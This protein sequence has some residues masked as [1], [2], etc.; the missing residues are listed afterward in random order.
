[1]TKCIVEK[2]Y[3]S[4][5]YRIILF[6][7]NYYVLDV[8]KPYVVLIFPFLF[9]ILP[10]KVYRISAELAEELK[11]PSDL[12]QN[13]D[14]KKNLVKT[15]SFSM[16]GIIQILGVLTDNF[17]ISHLDT[18]ISRNISIIIAAFSLI[19]CVILRSYFGNLASS[20]LKSKLDLKE[21]EIIKIRP[22]SLKSEIGANLG[23]V[24]LIMFAFLGF[25]AYIYA[26]NIFML[27][28]FIG[29]SYMTLMWS[30]T[31][32]REDACYIKNINNEN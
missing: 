1:M 12:K 18:N 21:I 29:L 27:V 6:K 7:N 24:F 14:K 10:H 32:V 19:I 23:Y 3:K 31:N 11:V 25:S 9:W 28:G 17:G 22:L 15:V 4:L 20:K 16:L 13:F 2:M 30:Q 26:G 8:D 5:R